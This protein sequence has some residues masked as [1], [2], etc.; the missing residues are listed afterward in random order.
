VVGG[1][2]TGLL[3]GATFDESL[4]MAGSGALYGGISEE[5]DSVIG[6][7]WGASASAG[8]KVGKALTHA[9]SRAVITKAQGG[10]WSA[11]FWSGFA[12]SA[13]APLASNAHTVLVKV[14]MSTIVGGIVSELGGGKFANGT[15][16]M[17]FVMLFND[18]QHKY[19]KQQE[20]NS[21]HIKL[22]RTQYR[23]ITGISDEKF[24]KTFNLSTDTITMI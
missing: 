13:L 4:Q 8:T 22:I 10:K 16:T 12:N 3:T 9:I 7:S 18:L 15:V 1:L 17:A 6:S 5:V 23:R 14:A 24:I 20:L 19:L 11:G 21:K 2:A